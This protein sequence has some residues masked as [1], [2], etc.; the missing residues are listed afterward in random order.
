MDLDYQIVVQFP[1]PQAIRHAE[2]VLSIEHEL[3]QAIGSSAEADGHDVLPTKA[4]LFVLSADPLATFEALRTRLATSFPGLP[5]VAASRKC[6]DNEDWT[7]L[8][9]TAPHPFSLE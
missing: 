3:T 8:S 5:Y 9:S 4:N 2:D 1:I 7:I 6:C